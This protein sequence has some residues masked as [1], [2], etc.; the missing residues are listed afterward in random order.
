QGVSVREWATELGDM[1]N[2]LS[3]RTSWI[4]SQFFR[5]PTFSHPGGTVSAQFTLSIL[6]NTGEA[7]TIFLT[8][9]GSDPIDGRG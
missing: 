2:Y 5:P 7:G 6:N 8:L 4:D 3:T 1:K 9:D